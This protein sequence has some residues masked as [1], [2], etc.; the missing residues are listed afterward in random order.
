VTALHGGDRVLFTASGT[1]ALGAKYSGQQAVIT[2]RMSPDNNIRFGDGQII[3]AES[4]ELTEV[5]E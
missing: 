4:S 5:T 1:D 2:M 3:W